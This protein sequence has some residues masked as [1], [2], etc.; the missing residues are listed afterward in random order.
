MTSRYST[1]VVFGLLVAAC[2]GTTNHSNP[3]A[4]AGGRG[5][6]T[7]GAGVG[8]G[9]G[10]GI[11]GAGGSVVQPHSVSKLT[12]SS[13]SVGRYQKF[14][15][16]FQ[17]SRS[18]AA[19][20][21]LPYY[22][23]DPLD[24]SANDPGR[25][26]PYAADGIS[27]DA[28][29]TSPSGQVLSVPAFYFERYERTQSGNSEVMTATGEHSW[30]VRFAPAELGKY[31]YYLT[32]EDAAGKTRW[33][34][35]TGTYMLS[36][37]AS[38]SKGFVRVSPRDA[39]FLEY[40][41]GDSFVPLS[42]A[43]QWWMDVGA[44]SYEITSVFD[45]FGA[46]GINL[47]R[48]WDQDDGYKL[49][50]E[51]HFDAYTNADRNPADADVAGLP[52]GT[53]FNQRGNAEEDAIIE[54][55]QKNGIVIDLCSHGDP[56]WIWDASVWTDAWN[57]KPV[58]MNAAAHLAYWKRNFRYRVARWGY[59]T[60]V[61]SWETWNE[62]GHVLSG[63]DTYSFYQTY[64]AFQQSTDPY[65]HLRTTSQGSQAYSPGLWSSSAMDMATYHD[66]M[67][68]SR[69]PAGLYDDE[70]KFVYSFA[71]CL[72][73]P[74]GSGNGCSLGIGDG[75]TWSGAAKPFVWGELDTGTTV[76]NEA[77]PQPIADHNIIWAGLFSPL[78][79]HP[80]DWY[81][82]S[83][84]SYLSDKFAWTRI[85]RDFFSGIDYAGLKFSYLAT[86]DV[87][88]TSATLTASPSNLRVL[89]MRS[90]DGTRAYAWAQNRDYRWG[91]GNAAP[92]AINGSVTIPGM[93]AGSYRVKVVNTHDGSSTTA[94]VSSASGSV[95]LSIPNLSQ[96]VAI[97]IEP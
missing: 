17:L 81:F 70:A 65:H 19:D 63:D 26:S 78:G 31:T 93:K 83:K 5:A 22:Y 9:A 37:V 3:S 89:A 58:A 61:L 24:T 56:A 6:N 36:S 11:G 38:A 96:D 82:E 95:T 64:G 74:T 86:S 71:Q 20:S 27:V 91:T 44:R 76:W 72:R 77:N 51:G 33:P 97:K 54:A 75:S 15:L 28:H 29:F 7:G 41:S 8:G 52:K 40:D 92:A 2:S 1:V 59:S 43:R 55:A 48:L 14:E 18:F 66:Y 13:D 30:R 39:R 53:Q 94:T 23:Y 62:H 85:A 35:G 87:A 80:I 84:Q 10:A 88:I 45:Q 34:A 69:Y 47:V 49:T 25:N 90:G 4:G 57:P 42:S 79:T 12:P 60:S 73:T 67:M 32:I 68:S 50:V 21:L 46:S 16:S